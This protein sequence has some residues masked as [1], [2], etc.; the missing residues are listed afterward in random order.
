M[1]NYSKLPSDP[2]H[3]Q[4]GLTLIEILITLL[5]LGIGLL[6]L[7]ALQGFALQSGQTSFYRSQATNIAYEVSDF[8]RANHSIATEPL[9]QALATNLA[10]ER[11]PGGAAVVNLQGDD[12]VIT[13]SWLEDRLDNNDPGDTG[14]FIF[15]TQL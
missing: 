7:A 3:T 5:V 6:G 9:L 11:L 15:D 4:R 2:A 14:Q 8:G 12:L 1:L 10:T 13:V